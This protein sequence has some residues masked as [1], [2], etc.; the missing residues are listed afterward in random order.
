MPASL[1]ANCDWTR[2]LLLTLFAP[3]G[4]A[5]DLRYCGRNADEGMSTE[6]CGR[7]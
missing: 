7:P 1:L 2:V 4:L 5:L 3:V 6:A